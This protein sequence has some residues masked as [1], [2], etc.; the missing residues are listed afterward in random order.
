MKVGVAL[1][2]VVLGSGRNVNSD[3]DST[4]VAPPILEPDD[5]TDLRG[6]VSGLSSRPLPTC[7][8]LSMGDTIEFLTVAENGFLFAW[9]K[10]GT[11]KR[12]HK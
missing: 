10:S 11:P 9:G 6:V 7:P 1:A 4:S 5:S 8:A 3:P 2:G 12:E